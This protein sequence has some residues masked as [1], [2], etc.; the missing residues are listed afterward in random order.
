MA[1]LQERRSQSSHFTAY[2]RRRRG[3][4]RSSGANSSGENTQGGSRVDMTLLEDEK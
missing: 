1:V 3:R 2:T 4:R